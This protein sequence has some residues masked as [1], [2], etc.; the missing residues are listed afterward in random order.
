LQLLFADCDDVDCAEFP[1]GPKK[2]LGDRASANCSREPKQNV[3]TTATSVI[4]ILVFAFTI[5]SPKF[6][7]GAKDPAKPCRSASFA[8]AAELRFI[9]LAGLFVPSS[10]RATKERNPS[11][12]SLGCFSTDR[13]WFGGHILTEPYSIFVV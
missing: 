13:F 6:E 2:P 1:P 3:N 9:F 12:K 4:S 7:C 8:T 11:Q 5:I 10:I